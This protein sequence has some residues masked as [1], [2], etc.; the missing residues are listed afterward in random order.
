[1]NNNIMSTFAVCSLNILNFSVCS[2]IWYRLSLLEIMDRGVDLCNRNHVYSF[3]SSY[4]GA[5][6]HKIHKRDLCSP[7]CIN[8]HLW[9]N[10]QTSQGIYFSYIPRPYRVL[11]VRIM[12]GEIMLKILR[13]WLWGYPMWIFSE[14]PAS[15]MDILGTGC[16]VYLEDDFGWFEAPCMMNMLTN[17]VAMENLL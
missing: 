1:M 17:S 8:L 2:W 16:A 9:H 3:G 6:C 5:V 14:P 10:C 13:V 11:F 15:S 7:H 12:M 4:T